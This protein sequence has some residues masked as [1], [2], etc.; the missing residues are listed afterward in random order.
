ML[1][2]LYKISMLKILGISDLLTF[3]LVAKE[4]KIM[5]LVILIEIMVISKVYNNPIFC[6]HRKL[7][8]HHYDEEG[9][10]ST[11]PPVTLKDST[12]RLR[13]QRAEIF[14]HRVS[15][16]GIMSCYYALF[17]VKI[18]LETYC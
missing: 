11:C 2:N 15:E 13:R 10:T 4:F 16:I 8:R 7:T 5:L 12:R 18:C 3:I 1:N 6:I 17:N 9:L 14:T